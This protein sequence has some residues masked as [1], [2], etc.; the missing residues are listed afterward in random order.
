MSANDLR[1]LEARVCGKFMA[2]ANVRAA[3]WSV[4]DD[5]FDW[6]DWFGST[7]QSGD[8]P[9]FPREQWASYPAKRTAV[10]MAC[11]RLLDDA[12]K[13]SDDQWL[14]LCLAMQYG[15]KTRLA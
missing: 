6:S 3:G 8:V 13:L 2:A 7:E 14:T 10:L 4:P 15:G 1:E 5:P 12:D 9:Q 11:D